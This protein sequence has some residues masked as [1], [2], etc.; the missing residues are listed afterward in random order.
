M[1]GS[2]LPCSLTPPGLMATSKPRGSFRDF[3][4]A[5]LA[6]PVVPGACTLVWG[7]RFFEQ[8]TNP[9]KSI[10]I[11]QTVCQHDNVCPL[12]ANC[13]RVRLRCLSV[14]RELR[15]RYPDAIPH[16]V[17]LG[18][19]R[20]ALSPRRMSWCFWVEI[21]LSTQVRCIFRASRKRGRHVISGVL[22]APA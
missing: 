3:F 13:R 19:C 5:F 16:A 17:T 21:V 1:L 11:P 18:R 22:C 6:S 8:V 7:S 10:L 15:A 9:R 14:A 4:V 2:R 20:I 12:R